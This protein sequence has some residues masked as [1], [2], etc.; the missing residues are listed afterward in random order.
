MANVKISEL[1]AASSVAD[2]NLDP[3][4]QT[5]TTK[6]TTFSVIKDYIQ[7]AFDAIY[8]PLTRTLNI[9][10]T[11][12]SLAANRTWTTN[13]ILE[14]I[15]SPVQGDILYRGA[16]N[17][18]LLAPGTDGNQ[19]TTHG[20][21]ANP[22][23]DNPASGFAPSDAHYLTSQAESG[24]SNEVNLGALSS[25]ILKHTVSG[26]I[27]T[28]ATAT[29]GT[30]YTA[31]AFKTISVSGQSDV[32]ADSASDTLTLAA[33]TNVT[34]TTNAS[35]DTVTIAASTGGGTIA[36]T[37]DILKGDNSGN[38][39]AVG[40][41]TS[42]KILKSNGTIFA[43]ST[44]TYASP[45]TSGNVLTSDG[46]NW[47][48]AAAT[49]S[50]AWGGSITT[51]GDSDYTILST[52]KIV[53]TSAALTAV[54]TWT[55]PAASALTAGYAITVEDAFGSATQ[56]NR[57]KI[58]RAGSDLIFPPNAG[59]YEIT[60]SYQGV[61]FISD[62]VSK[63]YAVSV[64]PGGN[65]NGTFAQQNWSGGIYSA[66][67]YTLPVSIGSTGK[68]LQSNGTNAVFS[69]AT[70]PASAAGTGKIL[71]DNGT[72]F[73]ET[74]ATFPDTAGTSGNVLTS[75][76]TNWS[77]S[78]PTGVGTTVKVSGSDF[79]TSSTTLVDITGLTFAAAINTTYEVNALLKLQSTTSN[80]LKVSVAYSAAGAS[81]QFVLLR[82]ASQSASGG[83]I[84]AEV[85]GTAN[86][87]ASATSAN[88][89]YTFPI[90]CILTTGANTG[91]ITIQVLKISTGTATVYKGSRM[92]VTALNP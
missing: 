39:V 46:T 8:V 19:L 16:S 3:I 68:V 20:A 42:G 40:S 81:G 82:S 33:G 25:G 24:L 85:I 65:T 44:E 22:T 15:G 91:N 87:S 50:N 34:I 43:A 13:T 73:V 11:S 30:D 58:Q 90:Q 88:V 54:R 17:W 36:T 92:T 72:N 84:D 37:T 41:V 69:T 83:G 27:S 7:A 9:G 48:S 10:G 51:H 57:L 4:V 28:P 47:T 21:S 71:R 45:G 31:L 74:T 56:T 77:S 70:Y 75:D 12:Q 29:A 18:V 53:H 14:G 1:P 32:V 52:D 80:G 2:A 55:L 49:G 64:Q 67:L 76:G 79:T 59:T 62:G 89:D 23:W 35:T 66:S 78:A 5:G 86:G 63:W 61:T 6:K 60:T 38:A 26:S